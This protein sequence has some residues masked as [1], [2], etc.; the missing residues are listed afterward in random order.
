MKLSPAT[1]IPNLHGST[2]GDFW[3]WAYS[4]IRSNRNRGI[5]AEYLVGVALDVIDQPRVEWDAYDLSYRN[6]YIEVK[7][8]GYVQSWQQTRSSVISF[9]IAPK[10]AWDAATNTY[11]LI[12]VRTS[13]C[14]VFCL[15]DERNADTADVL[16]LAQWKFFVIATTLLK[17]RMGGQKSIR[18]G[19]LE[20]MCHPIGYQELKREV[21]HIIDQL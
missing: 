19:P 18:L 11:A 16:N 2:I 3:S 8:S 7:A 4:D 17:E 14:Y 20:K 15:H 10:L 13:D 12:P 5:F 21:D 6:R 9:G 1:L